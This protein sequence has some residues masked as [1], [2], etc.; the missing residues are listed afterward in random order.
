LFYL[1]APIPNAAVFGARGGVFQ[2]R[3]DPGNGSRPNF[4]KAVDG[5]ANLVVKPGVFA[6]RFLGFGFVEF[7][8]PA[9]MAIGL[10]ML[11]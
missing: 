11:G 6:L 2:Q 5:V 1:I 9:V 7:A 10:T 3:Y 8:D 4:H